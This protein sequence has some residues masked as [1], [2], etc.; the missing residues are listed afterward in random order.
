M[1]AVSEIILLHSDTLMLFSLCPPWW[2]H[3][4][5]IKWTENESLIRMLQSTFFLYFANVV[6]FA[7]E[8]TN[9]LSHILAAI[10]QK[11]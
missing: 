1:Q 6:V 2:S 3:G 11:R 4:Y 7:E 9:V 10:T 8:A 5:G